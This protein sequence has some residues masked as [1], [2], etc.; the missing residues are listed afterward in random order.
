MIMQCI[1]EHCGRIVFLNEDSIQ[2]FTVRDVPR[3]ITNDELNKGF[4]Q[5]GYRVLNED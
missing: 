2:S 5:L 4:E 1:G 3:S